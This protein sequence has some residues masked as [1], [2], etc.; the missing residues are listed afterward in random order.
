MLPR[1]Q[2]TRTAPPAGS[3]LRQFAIKG[4]LVAEQMHPLVIHVD[5][6]PH[7]AP[8]DLIAAW[9]SALNPAPTIITIT[10]RNTVPPPIRGTGCC[11]LRAAKYSA[12]R[13]SPI[14]TSSSGQ[15]CT[16]L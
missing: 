7:R 9:N 12:S 16:N 5:V 6:V 14:T 10:S 11:R 8:V 2:F 3:G 1:S 15:Y 13:T 4:V